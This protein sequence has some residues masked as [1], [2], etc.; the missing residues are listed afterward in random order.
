MHFRLKSVFG[1]TD[2]VKFSTSI[3]DRCS[4]DSN[5]VPMG[6]GKGGAFYSLNGSLTLS[7]STFTLNSGVGDGGA[8]ASSNSSSLIANCT[9]QG[10][11][12]TN[13]G[14]GI[15]ASTGSVA[16]INVTMAQNTANNFAGGVF[17][18]AA[19][20]SVQN[21]VFT[22]NTAIGNPA[23]GTHVNNSFGGGA[24][25]Q[26]PIGNKPVS[27]SGTTM[28]ANAMLGALANNGGTTQTM[29]PLLGSPAINLAGVSGAPL[30][31]QAGKPR[32]GAPDAGA[33]EGP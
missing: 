19:S 20:T 31:D 22:G 11:T 15:H 9:F 18:L 32:N 10:N 12:A 33:C 13:L 6:L 21:S 7:N 1:F 24:N 16:L 30:L 5:T 8:V 26:A 28:V 17:S 29:K 23:G 3:I 27:A 14:G 4:F 2:P 25:L